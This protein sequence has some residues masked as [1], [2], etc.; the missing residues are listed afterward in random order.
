MFRSLRAILGILA[1]LLV[2]VLAAGITLR[3]ALHAGEVRIPELAGLTVAEAS[4]A[5]LRGSLDL[6]IENKLYSTTVPAGRILS[7]APAAGSRVREGWQVRVVESLGPQQ[8]PIPNVVGAPMHQAT[9]DLR[10]DQLDLGTVLHMEAPGQPDFVLAQNPPPDAGIDQPRVNLLL[11]SVESETAAGFVMPSFVGMSFTNANRAAIALGLRVA[12]IGGMPSTPAPEP[13]AVVGGANGVALDASGQ[14]AA[15]A[16]PVPVT[17]G[18]PVLSQVPEA[19]F[20]GHDAQTIRLYF[21]RASS[22]GSSS[23]TAPGSTTVPTAPGS[24]G[25]LATPSAPTAPAP[26]AATVPFPPR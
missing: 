23:T 5:A 26:D 22:A 8:V 20:R 25:S 6:N 7:Q 1:L 4:D 14:P 13:A 17:P 12:T 16:A 10:R 19:G 21:Y 18:G 15:V 2:M 24:P 9:M 11:S 3:L